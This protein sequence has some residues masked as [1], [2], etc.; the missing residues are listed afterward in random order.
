MKK[1]VFIA[2][3]TL[4]FSYLAVVHVEAS[5]N[6]IQN[7]S[8]ETVSQNDLG[9]PELWYQDS[10]GKNN[11]TFIYTVTGHNGGTAAKVDMAAR[12]RGDAKWFFE[13]VSVTSGAQYNFSD[14][15]MS[16]VQTKVTVQYTMSDGSFK[17]QDIGFAAP[18][19]GDWRQFTRSFTVPENAVKVSV[20]H[21]IL[22]NGSLTVDDYSLT[23][24]D[25]SST[26]PDITTPP[27]PTDFPNLI[28]NPSAENQTNGS[29]ND[30]F[31]DVEGNT[32]VS[33]NTTAGHNGDSAVQTTITS[34]DLDGGDAKWI[35]APVAVEANADYKFSEYYKSDSKNV[36]IVEF[37]MA[38]G[39]RQF[40]NLMVLPPASNW[41][42][43]EKEFNVRPGT[44]SV[45]VFDVLRQVGT[46]SIDDV[47]LSKLP[48]GT[49]SEGLVS[50]SFDDGGSSFYT[51]TMPQLLSHNFHATVNIVNDFINQPGYMTSS[52]ISEINENGMEIG[53]H[54]MTHPYL[55]SLS[56]TDLAQ[57]IGGSKSVDLS[58][59]LT[60]LSTFAYPYGDWDGRTEAAIQSAGYKNARV[61]DQGFN[62]K[63]TNLFELRTENIKNDTTL[64]QVKQWIND[65]AQNKTWLILGLH[66]VG[67]NP[68]NDPNDIYTITPA[69]FQNI[70]DYLAQKGIRVATTD[71]VISNLMH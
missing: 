71:Y 31:T 46:I 28:L 1:I 63:N 69:M 47:S 66:D 70:L 23:S 3:M 65:A 36:L 43:V 26:P 68:T 55:T 35:W 5:T 17:Y 54:S 67:S 50:L 27:Q 44:V 24:G 19:P 32:S 40:T 38:D 60:P 18:S 10:F 21:R 34:S 4:A 16:T 49:F 30:W 7:H 53:S 62:T 39:T 6:L 8:F 51:E 9:S 57:E 22:K 56:D 14:Y 61:T 15:Y 41:T 59:G 11:P 33:F 20:F 37:N 2:S 52:Q 64:A 12:V 48:D 25:Q 42:K 29:P 58:L 13:P 45:T